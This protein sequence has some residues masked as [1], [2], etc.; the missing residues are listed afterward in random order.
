MCY[1]KMFQQNAETHICVLLLIMF[2]AMS[3]VYIQ[4]NLNNF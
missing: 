2:N 3:R 4:Q 1:I